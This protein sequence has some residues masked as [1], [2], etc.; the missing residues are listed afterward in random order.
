MA[1][2]FPEDKAGRESSGEKWN[3]RNYPQKPEIRHKEKGKS[4]DS[5]NRNKKKN[6]SRNSRDKH[7][8]S[9]A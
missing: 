8:Q 2:I 7:A 9:A 1:A 3:E 5:K 4:G 6:N